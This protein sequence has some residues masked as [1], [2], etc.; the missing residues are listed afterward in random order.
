MTR[1]RLP[2]SPVRICQ[3]VK[4]G[5]PLAGFD[6][7]GA[8]FHKM[9][10]EDVDLSEQDLTGSR[11]DGAR[12]TRLSMR[13]ASLVGAD[14]SGARLAESDLSHAS[15]AGVNGEGGR[16]QRVNAGEARLPG[17][18]FRRCLL[19]DVDFSGADLQGA[20]FTSASLVRCQFSGANLQ[21]AVFSNARLS[22]THLGE[23][24]TSANRAI[25]VRGLS[26]NEARQ[27][28]EKGIQIHSPGRWIR[29][30]ILGVLTI[31]GGGGVAR[32]ASHLPTLV[33]SATVAPKIVPPPPPD[34]DLR[35]PFVPRNLLTTSPLTFENGGF[36][37]GDMTSWG[38]EG[39]AFEEQPVCDPRPDAPSQPEGALGKCWLDSFRHG[40][41]GGG[42]PRGVGDDPTGTLT[43]GPFTIPE[44]SLSLRMGGGKGPNTRVELLVD[45][46]PRLEAMGKDDN[47]LR[48]VIWDVT[49][50]AGKEGRLC[51][52]DL[53]LGS[54]GR[55]YLDEIRLI[56]PPSL[57][58]TKGRAGP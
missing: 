40:D 29:W 24:L 56:P 23:A 6:L 37:T 19:I 7:R 49:P 16:W 46:E 33:K 26:R 14:F 42:P 47:V 55:V 36:E 21:G 18:R 39:P 27:W 45:G 32:L 22:K 38:V 11:W 35:V 10:L 8:D 3:E 25:H 2:R 53:S 17:A 51:L 12:L 13:E 28:L 57:P 58:P 1:P 44:G 34:P 30:G 54:W 5:N 50:F 31:L 20:D 9:W 4:K 48:E 43:S 15:L 52:V 41:V